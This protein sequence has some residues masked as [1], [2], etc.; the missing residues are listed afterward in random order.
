VILNNQNPYIYNKNIKSQLNIINEDKIEFNNNISNKYGTFISSV[1]S[2]I[3]DFYW[4]YTDD[5]RKSVVKNMCIKMGYDL[6]QQDYYKKFNYKKMNIDKRFL[7]TTLISG[8]FLDKESFHVYTSD[9]FDK[10]IAIKKHG[11]I[12]IVETSILN[13]DNP[14]ILLDY[15]NGKYSP[16]IKDD[17]TAIHTIEDNVELKKALDLS[18]KVQLNKQKVSM[19]MTLKQLQDIAKEEFIEI[20]KLSVKTNKFINRTK[21]ELYE[22]ILKN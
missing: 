17:G 2:V 22:E 4:G 18:N 7:Q 14:I 12:K 6:D 19:S 10:I 5:K 1:L 8:K 9:Y 16:I 13:K 21:K 3:D 15:D 20:H 11:N